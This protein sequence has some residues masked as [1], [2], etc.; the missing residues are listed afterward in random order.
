MSVLNCSFAV[1]VQVVCETHSLICC[2]L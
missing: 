2:L 1:I